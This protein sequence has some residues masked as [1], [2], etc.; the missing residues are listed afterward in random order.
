MARPRYLKIED[1]VEYVTGIPSRQSMA[2]TSDML[3]DVSEK[4]DVSFRT[5]RRAYD[6][7]TKSGII[8]TVVDRSDPFAPRYS[9]RR[10]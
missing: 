5:A 4:F 6:E 2:F 9:W 1:F 8:K 7:A 3:R 10:S